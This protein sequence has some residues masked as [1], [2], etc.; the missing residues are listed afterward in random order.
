MERVA[1]CTMIWIIWRYGGQRDVAFQIQLRPTG[2]QLESFLRNWALPTLL[3]Y[4]HSLYPPL[5]E[6]A[7]QTL[8]IIRFP[9]FYRYRPFLVSFK[10]ILRLCK[11]RA[12][13]AMVP[14]PRHRSS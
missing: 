13:L 10:L 3:T 2:F 8:T 9:K 6:R 7:E 14:R 12:G 4:M 1:T 5:F 11:R